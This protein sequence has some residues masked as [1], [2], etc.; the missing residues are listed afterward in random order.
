MVLCKVISKKYKSIMEIRTLVIFLIV[1]KMKEKKILK[2][3]NFDEIL[4]M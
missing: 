3:V 2:N 1:V 4:L